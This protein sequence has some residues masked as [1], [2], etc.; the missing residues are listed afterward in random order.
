MNF[1]IKRKSSPELSLWGFSFFC[2]KLEKWLKP[3][4][5]IPTKNYFRADL[6][7]FIT[8]QNTTT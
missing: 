6:F 5:K 8:L 4:S 1:I 3:D 7:T 2:Q